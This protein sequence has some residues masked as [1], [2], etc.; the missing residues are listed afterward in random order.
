MEQ[1]AKRFP[2]GLRYAIPYDT[3]IFVQDFDHRGL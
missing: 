1:M 3:T 2:E